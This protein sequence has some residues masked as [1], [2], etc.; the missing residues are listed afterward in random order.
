MPWKSEPTTGHLMGFVTAAGNPADGATVTLNGPTLRT[1]TTDGNGFYGF[2]DVA[3][4]VYRVSVDT[5]V[6]STTIRAG[7]VSTATLR[8]QR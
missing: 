6:T 8:L 2:V 1:A 7:V 3:P 4:G 5:V